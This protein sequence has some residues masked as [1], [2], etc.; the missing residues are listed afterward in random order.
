MKKLTAIILI[1]LLAGG[2]L[3]G[4]QNASTNE[5]TTKNENS[6][7]NPVDSKPSEPV[8]FDYE[9]GKEYNLTS[10]K[11]QKQGHDPIDE[12][13]TFL[14]R[15]TDE[16]GLELTVTVHGNGSVTIDGLTV[17]KKYKIVEITGWSWRYTNNGVVKNE[18]TV[19][20]T[21][22][23][24]AD[25]AEFTLNPTGNVIMFTNERSNPYWLDGDSWCNNIFK[26]N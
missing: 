16:E 12:N 5:E 22:D 1:L 19:V 6:Q 17:G 3:M 26:S 14:F 24:I 13:Q 10:L 18:T 2:T 8:P 4:C 20:I 11:I 7:N 25:G 15:I 21:D 23:T 9:P